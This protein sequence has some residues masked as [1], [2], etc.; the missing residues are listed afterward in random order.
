MEATDKGIITEWPQSLVWALYDTPYGAAEALAALQTAD[1][2]WLIGL[3][4]AAV[5]EKNYN[6]EVTFNETGDRTGMS[7][8][9]TGALIGGLIGLIFPP[10]LIGSAAA[11]AAAGGLG[12]RLRDAGFEDN[13]L[14]AVANELAPGQSAIVAVF[15]HQWTDDAVRFLDDAAYRVGWMEITER[16]AE[17]LSAQNQVA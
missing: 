7:G 17:L 14:R 6:G 4:N 2:Q 16:A 5:V 3:E 10:A 9:G 13:A 1:R 15:W 8:L 12:A 11:G